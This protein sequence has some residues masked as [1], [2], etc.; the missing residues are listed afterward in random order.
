[1][2]DGGLSGA[3]SSI[4]HKTKKMKKYLITTL[5]G[6]SICT[7]ANAQ[8]YKVN[9]SSGKLILNLA[10]IIVEGYNGNQIVFS[11]ANKDTTAADP[12][13]AGLQNIS[14]DG[15]IDNTGLGLNV[16]E[17]GTNIEVHQIANHGPVKVLVPKGI[18]ITSVSHGVDDTGK[19][20][21][22]N[23][24]NEIEIA[25]DYNS[26]VLEN[27]TGPMT[28]STLYGGVDAKFSSPVKGP[29][30]I[31]S[32]Y[33]SVDVSLPLD[34]KANVKLSTSYGSMLASADLKIEIEKN[35]ADNM[36]SYGKVVNGKMNGGGAEFKLTSEY[37]KIYLRPRK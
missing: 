11:S 3:I 18:L 16:T 10:G 31:A 5:L 4:I 6:L 32:T 28:V 36:I 27:V 20:E 1:M 12:R 8:E 13:A 14:G 29:V 37:G 9:K 34:T 35:S 24:P 30:S 17:N 21:F 2:H 25:T 19:I 33:A 7:L 26:I 22:K 23:M 15:Y